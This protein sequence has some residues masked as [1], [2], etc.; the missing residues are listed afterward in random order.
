LSNFVHFT[1]AFLGCEKSKSFSIHPSDLH[2]VHTKMEGKTAVV[3]MTE[4]GDG[5]EIQ[6]AIEV[7]RVEVN[8]VQLKLNQKFG[9]FGPLSPLMLPNGVSN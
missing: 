5:A 1:Y 9:E 2:F 7:K 8:A 3:A 4:C 6:K